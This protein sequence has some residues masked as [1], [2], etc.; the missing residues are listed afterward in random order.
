MLA[1]A[2][3]EGVTKVIC[4]GTTL[5][6]SREGRDFCAGRDNC[7]ASA[8]LHPH[9]I[10]R[11]GA[12]NVMDEFAELRA[13]VDEA[14]DMFAAIGECGLDYYYHHDEADR[15]KQQ[16]LLRAHL[17]LAKKHN[18]PMIFHVRDAQKQDKSATGQAFDDFFEIL[19]DYQGIKGVVH[20]FSAT[21]KEL[22]QV[23][24]R[25]LYVGLNGIMTFTK[26]PQQLEAAKAVP[27][28][29]LLLETDAPFLTPVPFRGKICEPGH[30]RV[31]ATFLANLR[32]EPLDKLA[33]ASTRNAKA[34]FKI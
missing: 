28:N 30:V 6:G 16:E 18:L 32:G 1:N 15:K 25:G 22:D 34:L 17:Q 24:E 7:Y 23:I 19:K 31:T 2:A 4:V 12:H 27:L 33:A 21:R 5:A 8:A 10:Q 13:M 29:K 11:L 9:E 3:G 26:D 14:P 20:S